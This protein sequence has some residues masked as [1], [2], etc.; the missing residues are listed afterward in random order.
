[1]DWLFICFCEVDYKKLLNN[2]EYVRDN[3]GL[4]LIKLLKKLGVDK[5]YL[6]G[7]DGYSIDSSE[8]FADNTMNF[9]VQSAT[10]KS[11]N[12]GITRELKHYS[13]EMILEFLTTPKFIIL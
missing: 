12:D 4:M 11:M 3:S 6:A 7:F 1:M 10:I 9:Y 8:N 13:K 5:I 2:T